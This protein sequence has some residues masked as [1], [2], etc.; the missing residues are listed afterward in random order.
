MTLPTRELITRI[1]I[2]SG[3]IGLNFNAK[4]TY[5]LLPICQSAHGISLTSTYGVQ[6]MYQ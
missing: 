5:R 4:K 6:L 2:K 1:E 3:K